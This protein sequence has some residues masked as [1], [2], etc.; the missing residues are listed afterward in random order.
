MPLG[1]HVCST[2]QGEKK[3][4][5]NESSLPCGPK[6]SFHLFPFR[7]VVGVTLSEAFSLQMYGT[8]DEV[9]NVAQMTYNSSHFNSPPSWK[10]RVC[11]Y[12]VCFS[13]GWSILHQNGI[14]ISHSCFPCHYPSI[15]QLLL[16][17]VPLWVPQ[18][19][20]A[21]SSVLELRASAENWPSSTHI[22]Q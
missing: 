8:H 12:S 2:S 16:S 14:A 11:L 13:S 6:H 15:G 20:V 17:A 1:W 21:L 22:H 10:D 7:Q 18:G 3:T 19:Q 5:E 9:D 4:H